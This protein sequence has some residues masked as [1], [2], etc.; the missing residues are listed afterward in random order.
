MPCVSGRCVRCMSCF[1]SLPREWPLWSGFE[2]QF[3]QHCGATCKCRQGPVLDQLSLQAAKGPQCGLF[4]VLV[5]KEELH[6]IDEL[7]GSLHI[8]FRQKRRPVVPEKKN[9]TLLVLHW[10][11]LS[12]QAVRYWPCNIIAQWFSTMNVLAIGMGGSFV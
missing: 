4:I 2:Q 3:W 11:L 9:G 1:P 12:E 10:G 7:Q 5:S 8:C 6:F